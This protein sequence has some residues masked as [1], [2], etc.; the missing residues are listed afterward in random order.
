MTKKCIYCSEEVPNE[1]VIDFCDTCG[2]NVWGERMFQTI[3]S[4]MED[5]REKGD[6][7]HLKIDE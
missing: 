3:V 5:A 4:N 6:L 1:R 7:C 2:K